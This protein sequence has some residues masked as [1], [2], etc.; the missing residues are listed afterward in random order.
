M[1]IMKLITTPTTTDPTAHWDRSDGPCTGVGTDPGVAGG[2]VAPRPTPDTDLMVVPWDE[3]MCENYEAYNYAD[4]YRPHGALGPVRPQCA[5]D[6]VRNPGSTQHQETVDVHGELEPALEPPT[7]ATPNDQPTQI[8]QLDPPPR[9]ES[10]DEQDDWTEFNR[11]YHEPDGWYCP[12]TPPSTTP[13]AE[14]PMNNRTNHRVYAEPPSYYAPTAKPINMVAM[15]RS[16]QR[17]KDPANS[18]ENAAPNITPAATTPR[19]R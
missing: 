8:R 16:Q 5:H 10:Q 14:R 12:N 4:H 7:W 13:D 19:I 18:S 9:P 11:A 15:T 6:M 2:P 1:R 3:V 17:S